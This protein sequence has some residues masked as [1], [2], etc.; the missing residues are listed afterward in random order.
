MRDGATIA[1]FALFL[2]LFAAVL[3]SNLMP[4]ASMPILTAAVFVATAA[5]NTQKFKALKYRKD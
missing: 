4:R 3:L 1:L 5:H 2:S